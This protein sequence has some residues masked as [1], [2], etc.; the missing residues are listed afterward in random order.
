MS[1]DPAT[2]DQTPDTPLEQWADAIEARFPQRLGRVEVYAQ[3]ASTQDAAR[4]RIAADPA[5]AQGL[6]VTA[7]HQA[8]GRGRL[9]R[10]WESPGTSGLAVSIVYRVGAASADRLAFAA[11]VAVAE[12]LDAWLT[13]R[14][15][16]AHI[17][18]PNDVV[19]G[20]RKIAGILVEQAAG[21]AVVG[22]G[23]NVRTQA[24]DLPPELRETT[25]SLA[26]RGAAPCRLAVLLALLAHLDR[27]LS[28]RPLDE[29]LE[30][31]RRRSTLRSRP[32]RFA[33][34]GRVITGQVVDIDPHAGLIVRR[35]SGELVHLPADSTSVLGDAEP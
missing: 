33:H 22:V 12:T 9:G 26:H 18:W 21:F 27:A 30:V 6:V 14:G 35:D 17:K 24:Q 3:T 31:W 1:L 7:D 15:Q 16:T 23:I 28:D 19:V 20:G 10:R 29:L 11:S 5:R 32:V 13:P 34:G 4:R 25:T 2:C 8:A